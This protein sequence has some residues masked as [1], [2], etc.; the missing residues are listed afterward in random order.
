MSGYAD[1]RGFLLNIYQSKGYI[2]LRYPQKNSSNSIDSIVQVKSG[3]QF[4]TG[5]IYMA[6][7]KDF[8]KR[9]HLDV[10][11]EAIGNY[12]GIEFM[13]MMFRTNFK[14]VTVEEL[15]T[16]KKMEFSYYEFIN[17]IKDQLPDITNT[18]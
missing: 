16:K 2:L 14:G 4:F 12:A 1:L 3:E 17:V 15:G 18:I 9:E 13:T 11:N 6:I 8:A 5:R 10:L 7:P